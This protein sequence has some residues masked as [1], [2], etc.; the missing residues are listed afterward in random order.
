MISTRCRSLILLSTIV[1]AVL[2]LP[3]KAEEELAGHGLELIGDLGTGQA[4]LGEPIVLSWKLINRGESTA[5]HRAML[6][7]GVGDIRVFIHHPDGSRVQYEPRFHM[8]AM[9]SGSDPEGVPIEPG[10]AMGSGTLI[11]QNARTRAPTFPEVGRYRVEVELTEGS[12]QRRHLR[13][14]EME[15]EIVAPSET[16]IRF[17]DRLGGMEVWVALTE[18]T[19][20]K[21]CR[22]QPT[23][24]CFE[25]LRA[26][27]EENRDSAYAPYLLYNLASSIS[28][29]LLEVTP[30][31]SLVSDLLESIQSRWPNHALRRVVLPMI[32]RTLLEEEGH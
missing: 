19:A 4:V 26:I 8:D 32:G 18:S 12:G 3:L 16:D 2:G 5:K 15:L 13:A 28:R 24:Q 1:A 9:Y 17:L 11:V 25:E 30:K 27:A 7:I 23:A 10:E 14:P 22:D 29:G 31:D 20:G 21:Y 6:N